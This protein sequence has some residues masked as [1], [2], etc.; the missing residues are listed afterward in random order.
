MKIKLPN[1]QW[2]TLRGVA[3]YNHIRH[4]NERFLYQLA[5]MVWHGY[6]EAN[7]FYGDRERIVVLYHSNFKNK[8]ST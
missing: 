2:L 1:N 5:M 4:D 7:F 6:I 8:S 3:E